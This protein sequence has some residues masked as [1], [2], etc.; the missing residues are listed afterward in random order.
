VLT[1][2]ISSSSV[3]GA[4]QFH[5]VVSPP[6]HV[7]AAPHS[8]DSVGPGAAQNQFACPANRKLHS[9]PGEQLQFFA[10]PLWDRDL[11]VGTESGC[12]AHLDKTGNSNYFTFWISAHTRFSWLLNDARQ[13]QST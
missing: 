4:Q 2:N 3:V 9:H 5:Q 10:Y 8:V 11:V 7:G 13:R 1:S 12:N 6:A